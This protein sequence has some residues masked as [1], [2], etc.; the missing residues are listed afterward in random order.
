MFE[1]MDQLKLHG[2]RE[3]GETG[4]EPKFYSEEQQRAIDTRNAG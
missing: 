4:V 3:H 2:V 1:T